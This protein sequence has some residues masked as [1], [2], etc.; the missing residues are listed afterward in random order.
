MA[1]C[2]TTRIIPGPRGNDGLNGAAGV[3]GANAF[4][5][6]TANFTVP[7]IGGNGTATVG[8]TAWMV[9]GEPLY[10]QN[11]GTF[12]VAS[13][14]DG[15]HVVLTN[16]AAETGNVGAGTVIPIAS[17]LGPSGFK[18]LPGSGGG[19][20]TGV[21]VTTKGDL[22]THDGVTPTRLSV[23]TNGQM[24]RARS[25]AGNGIDWATIITNAGAATDDDKIGGANCPVGTEQPAPI[26]YM[27]LKV[28]DTGALQHAT[29]NAKGVDAVDLQ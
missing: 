21:S 3:A 25:A 27:P 26:Q 2:E 11:G 14:T 28:T 20:G 23:G 8:S 22:Q 17:R 15:T 13:I 5:T 18:G 6:L 24:V 16:S 19:P 9:A 29:G 1:V 7:A 12:Y 10:L 4:T